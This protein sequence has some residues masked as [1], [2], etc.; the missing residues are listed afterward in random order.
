M[1]AY[2][3]VWCLVLCGVAAGCD[4]SQGNSV[5]QNSPVDAGTG[6]E[7][8]PDPPEDSGDGVE[9]AMGD[10]PDLPDAVD[11]QDAVSD[12]PAS[13]FE[14]MG[15]QEAQCDRAAA[16]CNRF[17][18]EAELGELET[19]QS[20]ETFGGNTLERSFHVY[21]PTRA[22][23]R[24]PLFIYLHGGFSEGL[25]QL[26]R[27]F[28][29]Y[30]DGRR[31][32]WRPNTSDCVYTHPDGY[33]DVQTGQACTPPA[34]FVESQQPFVLVLADGLLDDGAARG[35]HWEDG[36]VPSPGWGGEAQHRDDVGFVAHIIEVL[37]Q[38]RA[39]SIDP[40]RVYVAGTSN[41]GMMAQRV[42]CHVGSERYPVLSKV[43][44]VAIGVASLPATL[45]DGAQG[46]ERCLDEGRLSLSVFYMVGR[47]IETPNCDRYPCDSPVLDGDG[48]MLYGEAGQRANI[49]SPELGAVVSH[50]DAV[51]LWVA[52]NGTALGATPSVSESTLGSFATVRQVRFDDHAA[53]VEA[54]VVDGGAHE[55]S[56][57]RGDALPFARMWE[58]VARF[59]RGEDGELVEDLERVSLEG[60]W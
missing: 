21:T 40:T 49:Y 32:A 2:V 18:P 44:A 48:R 56:A 37:L 20:Q 55:A 50:E 41:G 26:Q 10:T 7:D 33:A 6:Q 42:A 53:L 1:R 43:S 15:S 35:R 54:V 38:E 11:G 19:Y 4:G 25:E 57:F 45:V 27:P 31:T 36:R 24:V 9:D 28:D 22:Q 23:G 8:A 5:P 12:G 29:E 16:F 34:Q 52:R 59:E 39:D 13:A 58:F 60:R 30:A 17:W 46:R 47:G 14:W 51:S 3:G